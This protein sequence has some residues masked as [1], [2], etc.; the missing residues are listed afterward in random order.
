MNKRL[1][2]DADI[3]AYTV[4]AVNEHKVDWDGDGNVTACVLPQAAEDQ[5]AMEISSLRELYPDYKVYACFTGGTNWRKL[6]CESYKANRKDRTPPA[7]LGDAKCFIMDHCDKTLIISPLEADDV[8]G[9]AAT[10]ATDKWESIIVS[11]DKDMKT[12]IDG[13]VY[14]P[15]TGEETHYDREAAIYNH[16]FQTLCGDTSDGYSGCPGIG[17]VRARKILEGDPDGRWDRV[18]G[19]FESKGMD[20]FAALEQSRL[21][22]ILDASV[23]KAWCKLAKEKGWEIPE[24]FWEE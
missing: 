21:A 20:I 11:S 13:T 19:A 12:I 15:R 7:L 4:A 14:N 17:E 10:M 9:L 2:L 1:L 5:V 3:L 6:L 16:F 22:K 23:W 8:M 18:V 24:P